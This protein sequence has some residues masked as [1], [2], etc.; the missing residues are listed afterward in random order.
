MPAP[1]E[2]QSAVTRPAFFARSARGLRS[3]VRRN[4]DF[5]GIS[6]CFI[7][8]GSF[9]ITRDFC[10]SSSMKSL[11]NHS[12]LP[13]C[14]G[15]SSGEA[16]RRRPSELKRDSQATRF[17]PPP[18]AP[19][20]STSSDPPAPTRR[21]PRALERDPP[22]HPIRSVNA[23]GREMKK[24]RAVLWGTAR[25]GRST[26]TLWI[27]RGCCS[28]ATDRCAARRRPSRSPAHRSL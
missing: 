18:T 22:D 17:S 24:S 12:I 11:R 1:I 21:A 15:V 7:E 27:S 25:L 5:A 19:P 16:P 9:K 28:R 23:N 10:A 20:T 3:H 8:L 14:S 13:S 26:R 6:N 4:A 2:L